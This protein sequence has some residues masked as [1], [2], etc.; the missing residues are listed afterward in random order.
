MRAPAI[1]C[2][3]DRAI[4]LHNQYP[5]AKAIALFSIINETNHKFHGDVRLVE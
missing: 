2:N 5:Q 4:A 1:F 3:I